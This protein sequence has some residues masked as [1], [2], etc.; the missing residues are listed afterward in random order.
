MKILI[1]TTLLLL[2]QSL[3]AKDQVGG[4][5]PTPSIEGIGPKQQMVLVEALRDDIKEIRAEL[6]QAKEEL[7]DGKTYYNIGNIGSYL[8][9]IVGLASTYFLKIKSTGTY[10]ERLRKTSFIKNPKDGNCFIDIVGELYSA[11]VRKFE[12]KVQ[13][14]GRFL[15]FRRYTETDIDDAV[16]RYKAD[17]KVDMTLTENEIDQ[18]AKEYRKRKAIAWWSFAAS[19]TTFTGAMILKDSTVD[20]NLISEKTKKE[21]EETLERKER[22]LHIREQTL[23]QFA[24]FEE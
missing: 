16:K 11:K 24:N 20:S 18:M 10:R 15:K 9:G 3:I 14:R 5:E 4:V 12:K 7:K 6:D 17:L 21:L 8:T 1:I 2:S 22:E 13:S 19:V 23:H